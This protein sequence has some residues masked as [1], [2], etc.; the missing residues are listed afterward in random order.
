[1]SNTISERAVLRKP[2][3]TKRGW[4]EEYN[5]TLGRKHSD[6][7]ASSTM[8][9]QIEIVQKHFKAALLDYTI[10]CLETNEGIPTYAMLQKQIPRLRQTVLGLEDIANRTL[11]DII[12]KFAA[13]MYKAALDYQP[14]VHKWQYQRMCIDQLRTCYYERMYG[15]EF[16]I[17]SIYYELSTNSIDWN[18]RTVRLPKTGRREH[19]G[20]KVAPIT[21]PI[22]PNLEEKHKV[23]AMIV[24]YKGQSK[25]GT[26]WIVKWKKKLI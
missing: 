25:F 12:R 5:F 1:M 17:K 23:G 16:Y 15:L 3:R 10:E 9:S 4:T 18:A 19:N 14:V 26:K 2:I 22:T 7:V 24:I 8:L 20:P 6:I 11:Y 13:Q 21:F